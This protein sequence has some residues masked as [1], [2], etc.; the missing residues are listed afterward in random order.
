MAKSIK[1]NGNN[2]KNNDSFSIF[3]HL[4]KEFDEDAQAEIFNNFARKN[5]LAEHIYPMYALN[6]VFKDLTPIELFKIVSNYGYGVNP[7]IYEG[8]FVYTK[9]GGFRTFNNPYEYMTSLNF[10]DIVYAIYSEP[11]VWAKYKKYLT[12]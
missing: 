8:F 12:F 10:A 3:N 2:K 9:K 4:F 5:G 7:G 1:N 11:D 6:E